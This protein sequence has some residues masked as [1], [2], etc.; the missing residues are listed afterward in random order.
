[1]DGKQTI[2]TTTTIDAPGVNIIMETKESMTKKDREKDREKK[3]KRKERDFV[4]I[5]NRPYY[6]Y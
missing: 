6:Y 4:N 3:K 1:M 5:G 2:T